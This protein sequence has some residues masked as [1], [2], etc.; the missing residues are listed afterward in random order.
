MT[1][2]SYF[3]QDSLESAESY[4]QSGTTS[5]SRRRA[6]DR[7]AIHVLREKLR[8]PRVRGAVGRSRLDELLR[9]SLTQFP[10]TLISGRAGTG[11]TTLV[12][13][14]ARGHDHT[15]WYSVESSDVEWK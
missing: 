1:M 2:T 10:A 5:P 14:F 15:A 7:D 11:K 12:A 9:R 13:E 4:S 6:S 8:I 3:L